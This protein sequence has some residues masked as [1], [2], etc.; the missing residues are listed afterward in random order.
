MCQMLTIAAYRSESRQRHRL[1]KVRYTRVIACCGEASRLGHEWAVCCQ[2]SRRAKARSCDGECSASSLV[3]T[4]SQSPAFFD[5]VQ[6]LS[7]IIRGQQ[8]QHIVVD[9]SGRIRLAAN[10]PA[11]YA[12]RG[13]WL[14]LIGVS[15]MRCMHVCLIDAYT[16]RSTSRRFSVRSLL[17]PST[18]RRWLAWRRA[19]CTCEDATINNDSKKRARSDLCVCCD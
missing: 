5:I 7:A 2:R 16:C 3:L 8:Q 4:R 9:G 11:A 13:D 12:L 17:A 10:T 6:T 1:E 15:A 14:S 19:T 18:L